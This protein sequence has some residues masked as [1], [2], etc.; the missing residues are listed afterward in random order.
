[1]QAYRQ[2]GNMLSLVGGLCSITCSLLLPSL[3]F[4]LLYWAEIGWAK[5]CGVLIIM[6]VGVVLL[7]SITTE[8]LKAILAPAQK[9]VSHFGL[10]PGGL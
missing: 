9:H 5:R 6:T 7:V 4:L 1:M 2:F 8:N 10:L 3:C